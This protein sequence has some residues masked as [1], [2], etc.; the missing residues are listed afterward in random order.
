VH[1][2]AY[3]LNLSQNKDRPMLRQAYNGD[4]KTA[5]AYPGTRHQ[6]TALAE[7]IA[8]VGMVTTS[9]RHWICWRLYF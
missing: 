3:Q 1:Q 4:E 2:L 7:N 5:L 6:F 9:I 8:W